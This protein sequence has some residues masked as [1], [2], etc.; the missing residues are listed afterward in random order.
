M[1]KREKARFEEEGAFVI[2][3]V[4][5]VAVVAQIVCFI[6]GVEGW[7]VKETLSTFRR[8]I[9]SGVKSQEIKGE[10]EEA[11]WRR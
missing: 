3:F 8:G 11:R 2:V 6:V 7:H 9:V 4:V 10:L 1:G 5:E